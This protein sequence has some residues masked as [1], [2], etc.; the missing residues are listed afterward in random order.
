M[1]R[2]CIVAGPR[3]GSTWLEGMVLRHVLSKKLNPQRLGEFLHPG[4]AKH[5][6]FILQPGSNR[7]IRGK[8]QWLSNQ[9][10]FEGRMS[11]LLEADPTQSLTMRLFPQDYLFDFIDFIDAA[12]KIESCN[13]KFISLH[14]NIFERALSWI[15]MDYTG[16]VHLFKNKETDSEY[17]TTFYGVQEKS[18]IEPIQVCTKKFT[19]LLLMAVQDDIGRRLIS[20]V[21]E[22]VEVSYNN[23]KNDLQQIGISIYSTDILP[24]HELPYNKL[25]TNY[26]QLLDIYQKLK[27]TL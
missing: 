14:R 22:V 25:I 1:L 10:T 13:F 23:L 15:V 20:E 18:I 4:V 19:R 9:E 3:S 24:V 27:S 21:V 11:M 17:H 12:K 16:I 7:I 2:Y 6:Q 5:E 26:N 8:K